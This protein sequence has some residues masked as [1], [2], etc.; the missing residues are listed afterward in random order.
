MSAPRFDADHLM[1]EAR[2]IAGIDVLDRGAV[3]PLGRLVESLNAESELHEG[4]AVGMRNKLLRILANRLRMQRDFDAHPEIHDQVVKA[5]MIITGIPRTGSTKMQKLFSASGDFNYLPMWQTSHPSL[6]TDEHRESPQQR[7]DAGL[8]LE[9][10]LE[11]AS[12][13]MKYCHPFLAM[14]PEEDAWILEHSLMSPVFLGFSR[15]D[16]Y[17]QW[18]IREDVDLQFTF[19]RDTLKYLQ[20]QGVADPEKRWILKCPMY[21][22]I[23]PL[24]FRA[25]PDA[26]LIMTHRSPVSSIPSGSRMLELFHHC[27]SNRPPDLEGFYRGATSNLRRHM[28]NRAKDPDMRITDVHYLD[29]VTDVEAAIRKMY[30]FI[31]EDL[32]DRSMRAMLEWNEA[33]PK[34]AKGRHV[35]SLE[36]YGYTAEQIE[37]DF[38]DYLEFMESRVGRT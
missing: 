5:P 30:D 37:A 22:G 20:W 4:G 18:M 33:N 27:Y 14:E 10:W 11:Q 13:D 7:I 29:V 23:E 21:N 9:A 31:S 36:Q 35:Y 34:D 8:A 15:V 25:F 3:A 26:N 2:A 6:I 12:P 19:L 28:K 17:V 16:R 24:L 32:S 1:A 38:A